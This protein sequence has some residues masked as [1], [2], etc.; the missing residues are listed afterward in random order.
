MGPPGAQAAHQGD[1]DSSMLTND[2]A[3]SPMKDEASRASQL[4]AIPKVKDV[5]FREPSE[6]HR[7][8]NDINLEAEPVANYDDP[9][10]APPSHQRKRKVR[11]DLQRE[12]ATSLR[13]LFAFQRSV[14][15]SGFSFDRPGS[16]AFYGTSKPVLRKNQGGPQMRGV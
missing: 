6:E 2:G 4:P 16:E 3:P 9:P 10:P 11:D 12:G 5:R 15:S 8:E 7:V 1:D 14:N 13:W